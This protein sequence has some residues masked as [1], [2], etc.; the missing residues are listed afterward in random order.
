ML[1][2][3]KTTK[4]FLLLFFTICLVYHTVYL[5]YPIGEWDDYSLP[6]ASL[7]S[8]QSL[9]ISESDLTYYKSLFPNW[10]H[11]IDTYDL[12]GYTAKD[13]GELPWYF[14]TYSI[15]CIPLTLTLQVM[16]LPTVYAFPFTN[17]VVL[18]LS[19]FVVYKFLCISDCRKLLLVLA[20]SLNPI[21]FY[22]SWASAEV[23]IYSMLVISATFWYNK[24]YHRAA[25]FLSI[26]GTLNPT[27]MSVGFFMIAEY[28]LTLF[29]KRERTLSLFSFYV[30]KFAD[31]VGYGSCYIIGLIPLVYNYYHIGHINLTASYSGFTQAREHTLY[32]FLSYL[33]DLNY[34]FLPYFPF[35]FII[36]LILLFVALYKKHWHYLTWISA[37]FV[38]VILYSIMIHINSGMSGIARYNAW[39]AVLLIFSVI[40]FFDG[41][42]PLRLKRLAASLLVFST[43]LSGL[44]VAAYGPFQ[45]INTSYVRFTPIAEYILNTFP[46]L[47]SPLH[48]TFNS[49]VSH[50][51]GGYGYD[52]PIIYCAEDG[53]IRKILAAKKDSAL[54]L[55]KLSSDMH[56]NEWLISKIQS[57]SEK[58][59]YISIPENQKII[60]CSTY[61]IGSSIVFSGEHYNADQYVY[62]GLSGPE[63]GFSWT[64]SKE[65][66]LRFKTDLS[67]DSLHGVIQGFVFNGRQQVKIFVNDQLVK[68]TIFEGGLLD[69]DFS[70][71][72]PSQA[73]CI[74]IKLPDAISPYEVS[75][76]EDK[77][78]LGIGLQSI[79]FHESNPH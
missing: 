2:C 46:S 26:A 34:G 75:G 28:F 45:S 44:I 37:C 4:I 42:I 73:I 66:V 7:I 61:P 64:D 29:Q 25:L 17:L 77:R 68:D 55:Q 3:K 76:S 43:V 71:P 67:S 33:F 53:Y 19:L 69:F 24:N 13:G 18:M 15:A 49:R 51:D 78:I 11:Y 14:P 23:F 62:S 21:I 50:V 41:I 57:L 1:S 12:S 59:D 60:Y 39:G 10:A 72:G 27:I 30:S 31:I 54:L 6:V 36:A 16:K 40:L 52:T 20:L 58:E 32:R 74:R 22:L 48:S 63:D 5:P 47:Y 65:L 35:L 8:R 56:S 38:N 79:S 9:T 70:N